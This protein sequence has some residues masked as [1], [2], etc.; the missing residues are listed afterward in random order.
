MAIT[1]DLSEVPRGMIDRVLVILN[2]FDRGREHQRL[3][4]ISRR[5]GLPL[6][7]TYRILQRLT[8]WGMLE[9]THDGD[10]Q[11][12]LR[13]W[14][15]GSLAPRSM[16]LQHL[17]RPYLHDLHAVT[18]YTVHL[19]IREGDEMVSVERFTAPTQRRRRPLLVGRRNRLHTTAI[20][21]VLLAYAPDDVRDR[22]LEEPLEQVTPYTSVD[23]RQLLRTIERHR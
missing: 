4:D 20:G 23:P 16:E 10:Y 2:T 18:G 11:I 15:L 1:V 3:T 21:Q 9:R 5:C 8:V 22:V 19:G 13:L 6:A 7:T 17:A 12:G 14:E